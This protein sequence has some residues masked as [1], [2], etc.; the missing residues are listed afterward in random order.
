MG[1]VRT[2]T[3]SADWVRDRNIGIVRTIEHIQLTRLGTGT[4]GYLGL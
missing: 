1:I 3:H 4:G 2:R